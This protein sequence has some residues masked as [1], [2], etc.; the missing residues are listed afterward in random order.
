MFSTSGIL[1]I[2]P[3]VPNNI[4]YCICLQREGYQDGSSDSALML[5]MCAL[6]MFVLLLLLLLLLLRVC[7]GDKRL[8]I[9]VNT[10]S[11]NA[12]FHNVTSI[13]VSPHYSAVE[14]LCQAGSKQMQ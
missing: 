6:Q 14:L 2:R 12:F 7:I 10:R 5:T 9:P 4:G 13:D 3:I 1:K 11:G 8:F